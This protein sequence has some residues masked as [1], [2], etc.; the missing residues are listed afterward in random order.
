MSE[1]RIQNLH[2]QNQIESLKSSSSIVSSTTIQLILD[3]TILKISEAIGDELYD[4]LK[5]ISNQIQAGYKYV[6]DNSLL[7]GKLQKKFQTRATSLENEIQKITKFMEEERHYEIVGIVKEI[8]TL[9]GKI[10][11]AMEEFESL[12]SAFSTQQSVHFKDLLNSM[13]HLIDLLVRT[14][15]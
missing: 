5:K 10:T 6:D 3:D 9:K 15:P 4:R 14:H 8:D 2:L 12:L 7:T 11:S 1:L 13:T